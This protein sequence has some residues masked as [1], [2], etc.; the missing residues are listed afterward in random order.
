MMSKKGSN[1]SPSPDLTK[2]KRLDNQIEESER[3]YRDMVELSP[4]NIFIIDTKGVLTSCN[5]AGTKLLGYSRDEI[6][7]KHFSRLGTLRLKDIPKYMKLFSSVLAGKVTE[8][9]EVT[10][11]R[12]DGTSCLVDVR[13]NLL[14]FNQKTVIQTTARDVTERK[15]LEQ[16]VQD[17]NKQLEAQNKEL[18]L[19]NENLQAGE[20]ELY[21]TL[22]E[23][24]P[25]GV[26]IVQ[27]GKYCFVNPQ[28]PKLTGYSEDELLNMEPLEL[29]HPEDR[30]KVRQETVELLKENL[31]SPSEFRVIHKG[32]E[33]HWAIRTV[34]S[35]YYKGKRA[36]LGSFIDIT[37]FK[38]MEEALREREKRFS[39]I[40]E[41]ALE[42]IWETDASGKYTYSS[43]VVE[44]ILGYKSKEICKKHF[45]D[46]FHPEDREEM[47]KAALEAFA[48]KEPF[49]EF[50]NRNI[51]KNG[52]IVWLST[53]GVPILDEKGELVGYRGADTDITERKK[54]EEA[55]TN[56]ATRRRILIE[57]SRDGIVVLDQEGNVYEANQR[58][59]EMLGYSHE[60]IL[61]LNVWDWEFQY[62]P[63]QVLD[64]I[65]TVDETGDHF[66]T[67]HRRKDGTIY[68]VAISTNAAVFAGQKLIFC[69]CRDITE[70]KRTEQL[71]HDENYVLTLLAQGA[72]ISELLDAIVRLGES[73]DT[74][75]KGSVL[76]F[77]SS[78]DCLVQGSAPSLPDDYNDLLKNGLPIGPGMGSCGTA[79]YLKDRVIVPD[80]KN[81]P[82]FKPYQEVVQITTNNNLLS[83]WSQPIISSNGELLGTIAN[84]SNKVGEPND[85]SL[86]VLEWSAH[87]AA[88]A[89]ER[90]RAEQELKEKNERLDAQ[91]EELR[92]T[93]EELRSAKEQLEDRVK[94][95]TAALETTNK[96]LIETQEQLVRSEKLAA[97]GQLAG[98]VGHELRNPLGAIKNAVYYVRDKV[99]KDGLGQKEPRVLEF[100]DIVDDE[101][102]AS[103]KIISDLLGFS[104]VGKPSVS[105]THIEKV[106]KDAFS[107]V[108]IPEDIELIK[109][110]DTDLPLV[111]VDADQIRQVLVNLV[112]NATQAMPEGGKL[113]VAVR[114]K[115][116]FLE[117]K[118]SDTGHGIPG[119]TIGKIFDPL[120][121][122][123]AKGIGLGL[124]VCRTII[125]RHQGQIEAESKVGKGT[126]FTVKLLLPEKK[127]MQGGADGE[128]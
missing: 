55:L 89:I 119:D 22:T 113:T 16:E 100:L 34:N 30:E 26:Y 98:G 99:A 127:D 85:D 25:V 33:I 9:L 70:R 7:G 47:K 53:S 103:N 4:D 105:P 10:F 12:K 111:E 93:E 74:S 109:K 81:S 128:D 117:V 78:K 28:F 63:E 66:E 114:Q 18:Q 91:N 13:L 61:Q 56:E 43:P 82:L 2:E 3:L 69:V 8:P 90:K 58:F 45:Y 96:E 15:R 110:L 65:R 108:S 73:H 39:D 92:A 36:I 77:D 125:E 67:Q 46:L 101:I 32:G 29:V 68:N 14:K 88:I 102:N 1:H 112:T 23:N 62:P 50:V 19:L 57:Q 75:I 76:L 115:E 54:A 121:T 27:D 51:R 84:Y 40:V 31:L 106:I 37:G 24:S 72:E 122:T 64:M 20:K 123:K 52:E 35:I 59:T 124:A 17:K 11:L 41:N 94:E 104:R 87:I 116:S 6:V 49:H 95:R 79:A 97:I 71:Q 118:V 126:T 80:I 83:C 107:Y 5:T 44:E 38:R 60:E 21:R 42:W 86:K 120:F 48:R